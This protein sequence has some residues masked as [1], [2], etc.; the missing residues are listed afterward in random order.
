MKKQFSLA[1]ASK[2]LMTKR[3]AL[4]DNRW[5]K[6]KD[7]LSQIKEI[8]VKTRQNE[9]PVLFEAALQQNFKSEPNT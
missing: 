1:T 4:R 3:H 7:L 8:G 9:I 2:K 6:I 5:A